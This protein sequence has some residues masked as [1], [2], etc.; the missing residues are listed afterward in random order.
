MTPGKA[1]FVV[2]AEVPDPADR[3]N[4]DRWYETEHLRDA[5]AAFGAERAWRFWSRTDPAIHYAFY[6][7]PNVARAEAVLTSPRLPE[8]IAEFDRVWGTRIKRTRE[9]LEVAGASTP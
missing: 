9:V 8:L 7:F 6:E 1:C 5:L 4:F 3:P 2:R